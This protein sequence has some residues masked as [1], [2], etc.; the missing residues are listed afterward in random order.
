[1]T[2]V[3]ACTNGYEGYYPN[4]QAYNEPG[5]SYEKC[6]SPFAPDCAAILIEGAVSVLKELQA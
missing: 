3:T 4:A 6:A 5:Y 2:V 1:M